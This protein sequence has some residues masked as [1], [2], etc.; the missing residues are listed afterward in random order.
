[1]T[2]TAA[3]SPAQAISIALR[4]LGLRQRT[5]EVKGSIQWADFHVKGIYT[6]TRRETIRDYTIV[7]T[8]SRAADEKIAE[9]AARIEARTAELGYRF[10]V[11]VNEYNGRKVASVTNG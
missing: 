7:I 10:K 6:R 8:R 1:M 2:A 9:N 5:T 3:K 4:E 11:R